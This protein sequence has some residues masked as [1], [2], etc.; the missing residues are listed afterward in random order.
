MENIEESKMKNEKIFKIRKK[1]KLNSEMIWKILKKSKL[2]CA[3]E[4]TFLP[5]F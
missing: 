4:L 3:M 2:K 1:R 5:Y